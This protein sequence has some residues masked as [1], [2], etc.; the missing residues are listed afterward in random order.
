MKF[1]ILKERRP[2]ET[3]VAGSP[4]T[5]KKF[6]ALGVEVVVEKGAGTS[7]SVSDAAFRDAGATIAADALS[8]KFSAR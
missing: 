1:A 6:V 2:N 7:A 4:E 3:R 8:S 5:V